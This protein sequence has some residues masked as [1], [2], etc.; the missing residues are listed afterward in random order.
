MCLRNSFRSSTQSM[1]NTSLIS[2]R[3]ALRELWGSQLGISSIPAPEQGSIPAGPLWKKPVFLP[4]LNKP[5]TSPVYMRMLDNMPAV[6]GSLSL[7]TVSSSANRNSVDNNSA[8]EQSGKKKQE[9]DANM[10]ISFAS[11]E[12]PIAVDIPKSE[13]SVADLSA[14]RNSVTLKKTKKGTGKQSKQ[15]LSKETSSKTSTSNLHSAAEPVEKKKLGIHRNNKEKNVQ[16]VDDSKNRMKPSETTKSLSKNKSEESFNIQQNNVKQEK[17]PNL[18]DFNF[19]NS[20]ITT[21]QQQQKQ[22][23]TNNGNDNT[24]MLFSPP[25]YN[26]PSPPSIPNPLNDMSKQNDTQKTNPTPL[27]FLPSVPQSATVSAKEENK[28]G[29]F[30]SATSSNFA[31]F[32]DF[33][34]VPQ[35]QPE[36]NTNTNTNNISIFPPPNNNNNNNDNTNDPF[37]SMPKPSDTFET[38]TFGNFDDGNA[39]GDAKTQEGDNG[40]TFSKEETFT[41]DFGNNNDNNN[42]NNVDNIEAP[43]TPSTSN[44]IEGQ[45]VES[46]NT[47]KEEDPFKNE[48]KQTFDDTTA[49]FNVEDDPFSSKPKENDNNNVIN[50]MNWEGKSPEPVNAVDNPFG[51]KDDTTKQNAETTNMGWGTSDDG[52]ATGGQD[53]EDLKWDD[54]AWG[55]AQT[56]NDTTTNNNGN[57]NNFTFENTTDFNSV[58]TVQKTPVN[59]TEQKAPTTAPLP[60]KSESQNK[61]QQ[62]NNIMNLYGDI[63]G[64]SS[65]NSA[66]NSVNNNVSKPQNTITSGSSF[67]D[68]SN[69]DVQKFPS[70]IQQSPVEQQQ[71]GAQ[72][73]SEQKQQQDTTNNN[74]NNNNAGKPKYAM[75]EEDLL[76]TVFNSRPANTSLRNNLNDLLDFL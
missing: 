47:K 20:N 18:L 40:F 12:I 19:P 34:S 68:F 14:R 9:K 69:V 65:N 25:E 7:V 70:S 62:N 17:A 1:F 60:P 24:D 13:T 63:F 10:G 3:R 15:E 6:E 58:P 46:E 26:P 61:P 56:F 71:Q 21:Q 74:N 57:D 30:T 2:A 55:N 54:G 22:T 76:D 51:K 39:F 28:S 4:Y 59:E 41:A 42:N 53:G 5:V 29:G 31:D 67:L 72:S 66:T 45:K 36:Q 33:M 43:K 23:K 32:F 11:K 73:N 50:T 35:K 44:I 64:N 37:S 38:A 75:D 8:K 16:D 49:N 52:W 48:Q 27:L